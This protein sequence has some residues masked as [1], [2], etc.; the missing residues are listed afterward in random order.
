MTVPPSGAGNAPSFERASRRVRV[1][2]ADDH[3]L[4][5]QGLVSLL[6]EDEG[7]EVV[8][9]A[10]NGR[11]ALEEIQRLRPDVAL[12]DI[13]MPEMSGLEVTRQVAG[14]F[15]DVKVL[16]LTMHEEEA[17]FF[18]A[19]RSGASGYVLK[20]ASSDE[21]LAAVLAVDEGG[22]YL[23]PKL[24]GMVL[25][26][27]IEGGLTREAEPLCEPLTPREE[28]VLR[29]IAQGLTNQ[30]IAERLVLGL[31]TVKTH[32]LHV[33][34]KLSLHTRAELVAYALQR[35]LLR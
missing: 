35:G 12:L 3:K 23:P 13:T 17:F 30:E 24:A 22:V 1:V 11:E 16:I 10:V 14:Q 20:G 32:R 15:P 25:R 33:Y 2:V 27:Y 28:E 29:L 26:D 7:I 4:V 6:K 8:G 21:L 34:Q 9:Q 18:E 19:L 5:L 31:N